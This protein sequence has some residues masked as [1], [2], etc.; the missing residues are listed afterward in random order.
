MQIE[1]KT[2]PMPEWQADALIFF[3]FEKPCGYLPALK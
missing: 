2:A 3:A 1:W